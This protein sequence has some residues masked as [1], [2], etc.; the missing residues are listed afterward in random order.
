MVATELIVSSYNI[1]HGKGNDRVINIGRIAEEIE[2]QNAQLVGLQE[3]D[4]NTDR[5]PYDQTS[6]LGKKLNMSSIFGK[7]IDGFGGEYGNAILSKFPILDKRHVIFKTFASGE[8]RSVVAI[9]TQVQKKTLWFSTV[10]L[11]WYKN[12]TQLQQMRELKSFLTNLKKEFPK[13]VFI[14]SGDFNSDPH[15][16]LIKEFKGEEWIDVWEKCGNGARGG[17]FP[18]WLI[19]RRRIDYIFVSSNVKCDT[20]KVVCSNASDHC[21]LVATLYV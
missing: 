15:S 17:T 20:A 7:A 21:Q 6:E 18:S 13:D 16:Q 1:Q 12:E 9:R 11:D 5:N 3:V 14:V 10:H 2:K 4:K 8:Y 19:I